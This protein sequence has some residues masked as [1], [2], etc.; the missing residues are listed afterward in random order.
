[1]KVPEIVNVNAPDSLVPAAVELTGKLPVNFSVPVAPTYFP[2]P[3]VIT[4]FP[5][6]ATVV[7]AAE[8]FAHPCE[9]GSKLA[10]N[11]FVPSE[12]EPAPEIVSHVL[13]GDDDPVPTSWVNPSVAPVPV[14]V[15]AVACTSES[16]QSIE[17]FPVYVALML[18]DFEVGAAVVG[19]VAMGFLL[20]QPAAHFGEAAFTTLI[21]EPL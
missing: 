8:A 1:M 5:L 12:I 6:I 18:K 4:A 11:V 14:A 15:T 16:L 17:I 7:G 2:V 21:E 9:D 19:F 20:L 10:F 3:P 13:E